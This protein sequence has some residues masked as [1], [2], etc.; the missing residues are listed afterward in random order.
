M[1]PTRSAAP[2]G[3]RMS[4][5]TCV[6]SESGLTGCCAS[7]VEAEVEIGIGVDEDVDVL[8]AD[9]AGICVWVVPVD[10]SLG[11]T[12]V[13]RSETSSGIVEMGN[14]DL[15]RMANTEGSRASFSRTVFVTAVGS[16]D[17]EPVCPSMIKAALALPMQ[18]ARILEGCIYVAYVKSKA[19]Q[20]DRRSNTI[21]LCMTE[22]SEQSGWNAEGMDRR[23]TT[24]AAHLQTNPGARNMIRYMRAF[25]RHSGLWCACVYCIF[26]KSE[27]GI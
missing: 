6:D 22:G 23:R 7:R 25:Y 21:C 1:R 16:E 4:I 27:H 9:C 14:L 24:D 8:P 18:S 26:S 2:Q 13:E 19:A 17:E 20:L 5:A 15:D 3:K 11:R 10:V 12:A